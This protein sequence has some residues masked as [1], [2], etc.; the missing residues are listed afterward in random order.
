MFGHFV[1]YEKEKSALAVKWIRYLSAGLIIAAAIFP[2]SANAEDTAVTA[3]IALIAYNVKVSA[4][5]PS[6]CKISWLTNGEATSQVFFDPVR[7]DMLD[8]YSSRTDLDSDADFRH[9]VFL[10]DLVPG[11]TYHF[12]VVSTTGDLTAISNDSCF[13]T[14]NRGRSQGKGWKWWMW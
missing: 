12:R 4:V 1:G 9:M 5:T 10:S 14:R 7:H 6:G 2:T 8:E 3:T 13:T 11:S